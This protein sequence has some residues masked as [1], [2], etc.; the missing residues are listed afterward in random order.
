MTCPSVCPFVGGVFG[1]GNIY[2]N[3]DVV[4]FHRPNDLCQRHIVF[5]MSIFLSI[6]GRGVWEGK[7]VI[8]LEDFLQ[9]VLI[10]VTNL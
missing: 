9:R 7:Y 5:D 3:V 1:K 2:T 6:C 8:E 10:L 4:V